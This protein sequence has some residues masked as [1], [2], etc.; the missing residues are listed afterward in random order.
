MRYTSVKLILVSMLLLS[1][2]GCEGC[3]EDALPSLSAV[4]CTGEQAA[5]EA[6]CKHYRQSGEPIPPECFVRR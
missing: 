4:R 2:A 3:E 6:C 5:F 1:L